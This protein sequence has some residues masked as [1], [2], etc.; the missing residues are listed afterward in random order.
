MIVKSGGRE[1]PDSTFEQAAALAAYYS[2][3]R[4]QEKVEIDYV[5]RK[6]VKKVNG[7]APGFVIYHTN[8]SLVA[9]PDISHIHEE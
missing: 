1:L 3:G 7:G 4:E 9:S 5:E 6:F 8:Y 2:V